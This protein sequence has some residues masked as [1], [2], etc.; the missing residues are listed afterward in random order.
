M[1]ILLNTLKLK[2]LFLYM[3]LFAIPAYI[4]FTWRVPH[5]RTKL[6]IIKMFLTY[7]FYPPHYFKDFIYGRQI[8]IAQ[9]DSEDDGSAYVYP[10][11]TELEGTIALAWLCEK[12]KIN[13]EIKHPTVKLWRHFENNLL[14]N[15]AQN[16]QK[17]SRGTENYFFDSP[18]AWIGM[19][20]NLP[21]YG[22]KILSKLSVQKDLKES[23]AYWLNQHIA[24]DWVAVHYRGTDIEARRR[25]EGCFTNVYRI[26]IDN[27]VTYLKEVIDDQSKI[28]VCSDQA[29][30]IDK[31]RA[32]FPTRVVTRDI[33]RSY[34][35]RP[36]HVGKK[37]ADRSNQQK[38][39]L[40][41]VLILAKANL[42]YTTGSG[43]VNTAKY[44]NPKIKI[45]SL[46]GRPMGRGLSK[47]P[48]PKKNLF[49]QLSLPD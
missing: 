17:I 2:V 23:A 10:V 19:F 29:Q 30:F 8:V 3:F 12:M 43:F 48:I 49:N 36:L 47:V 46:D 7:T 16:P 20:F 22:H 15:S 13:L 1:K 38:D 26:D 42:I 28:F 39:A 37:G 27:Y 9:A 32:A 35:E 40:I 4:K 5:I 18:F 45:V 41:D 21:E 6:R 11:G 25:K 31:M 14:I 44:F 24:G 33:E 34:D